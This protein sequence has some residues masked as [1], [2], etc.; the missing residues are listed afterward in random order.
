MK[1]SL[2]PE[3]Q[4]KKDDPEPKNKLFARQTA[5]RLEGR[6][7]QG[8]RIKLDEYCVMFSYYVWP[9]PAYARPV[10]F[11]QPVLAFRDEFDAALRSIQDPKCRR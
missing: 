10:A 3:P 1:L 9:G 7:P 4:E 5:E 11:K 2:N 8:V 6:L